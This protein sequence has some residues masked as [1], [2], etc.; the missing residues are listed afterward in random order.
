[1]RF[2]RN[3]VESKRMWEDL[4]RAEQCWVCRF[5]RQEWLEKGPTYMILNGTDKVETICI[6]LRHC[7]RCGKRL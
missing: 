4:R 7:P 1:M 6:R 3:D 2:F 5:L